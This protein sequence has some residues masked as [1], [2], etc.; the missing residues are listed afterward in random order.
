MR[1]LAEMCCDQCREKVEAIE[2]RS[3]IDPTNYEA[4]QDCRELPML[5]EALLASLATKRQQFVNATDML[6]KGVG[7]MQADKD[8]L[9][10]AL[11]WASEETVILHRGQCY[12]GYVKDG[13]KPIEPPEHLQTVFTALMLPP[14]AEPPPQAAEPAPGAT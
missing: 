1:N 13:E 12:E 4:Q 9:Q 3:L 5:L 8:R 6:V 11:R 10:A 2:R 14:P 7:L